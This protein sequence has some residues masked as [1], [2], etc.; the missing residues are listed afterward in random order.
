MAAITQGERGIRFT[1]TTDPPIKNLGYELGRY[2]KGIDDW[3]GLLKTFSPLYQRHMAEQFET[4][5]A[6]TGSR[7]ASVDSAYAE[8]KKATGHGSKIGVYSGALR[9]SQTGGAGFS[10]EITRHGGSFGMSATSKAT[11]Y[12][13]Y[14]AAKRP[15]VRISKRQIKEY[16]DLTKQWTI[17]Q[18][19]EAGIGNASLAAAIPLGGGV[20][21]HSVFAGAR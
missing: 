18:A 20:A 4:E 14:F 2:A 9:S 3:S 11:S 7:W 21:T 15:V 6:A 13:K 17:T 5:G 8:R 16:L 12:G 19:R 10:A 1:F